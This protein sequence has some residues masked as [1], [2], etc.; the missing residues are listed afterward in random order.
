MKETEVSRMISAAIHYE[1]IDNDK[2]DPRDLEI[3]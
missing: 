1:T 3:S 2:N